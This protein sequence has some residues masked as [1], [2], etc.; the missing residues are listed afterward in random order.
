MTDDRCYVS[1]DH[2]ICPQKYARTQTYYLW[3]ATADN[4]SLCYSYA[5]CGGIDYFSNGP[6]KECMDRGGYF[7]EHKCSCDL[8]LV[9]YKCGNGIVEDPHE[10]CDD[11]NLVNGDGCN[12]KC[13]TEAAP[14]RAVPVDHVADDVAAVDT[15]IKIAII[16]VLVIL[17]AI[18]LIFAFRA[19]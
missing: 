17:L 4:V 3:R 11:G 12:S 15:I 5:N 10:E 1:C 8:G 6:A 9:C 2:S 7:H 14:P 19:K 16:A 13:A 18:G